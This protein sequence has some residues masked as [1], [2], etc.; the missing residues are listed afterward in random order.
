VDLGEGSGEAPIE[1]TGELFDLAS[2]DGYVAQPEAIDR[3]LHEGDAALAEVRQAEGQ[4]LPR[5]RKRDPR[6]ARTGAEI[7]HSARSGSQKSGTPERI[8][9]VALAELP[10]IGPSDHA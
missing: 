4:V 2:E 8:D 7:N 3:Q 10:S 9:D 5:D 1:R 6:Q